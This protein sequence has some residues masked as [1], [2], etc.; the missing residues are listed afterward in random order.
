MANNT[1]VGC[2]KPFP[3]V[4]RSREH[5]LPEW[6]A[7]EVE[8]PD[9]SLKQYLHDEDKTENELLRSHG[10]G[11]FVIK[12]V[13]SA[14][15]N[16][17]MSRL[18]GRAK[19]LIL[20]LMN[21]QTGLLEL[22]AEQRTTLSAWAIKTA[23]MIAS[24]QQSITD[25]PWHLFRLLGEKPQRVPTECF[26]FATQLPSLPKGFL[27]ACPSDASPESGR[28][29]QVRIA[30]SIHHLHF[31]VVIPQ[32]PAHR[33]VRTSGVHIPIWPLDAEIIVRYENFPRLETASELINFLA[34]LVHAGIVTR[35]K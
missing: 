24:A 29:V 12:N 7:K 20:D 35:R 21:L 27:Y 28:P 2:G 18:E 16:G 4:A 5:I 33:I 22:S 9:L 31:V 14:C 3:D 23:F 34:D 17:W 19:P 26:V 6:L 15:N 32:F 13:C 1:C 11:S 25:L 10:L 8:Q 30:F